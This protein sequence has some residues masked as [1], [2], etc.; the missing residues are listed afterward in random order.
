MADVRF[1]NITF[2][3]GDK[4][5]LKIFLCLWK[6]ARSCALSVRQAAARLHWCVV[7][8]V[9]LSRRPG[10]SMWEI[11]VC[12]ARRKNQCAAGISAYWRR[13]SGLCR[14]ASYDGA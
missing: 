12:S 6:K 7:C 11:N 8:S 5:I 2:H 14:M 4:C 9:S 13:I 3:Y 10:L 1:E